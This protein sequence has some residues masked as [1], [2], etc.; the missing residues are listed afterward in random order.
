VDLLLFYPTYPIAVATMTA[1]VM[2]AQRGGTLHA[3]WRRCSA[4]RRHTQLQQHA[5]AQRAAPRRVRSWRRRPRW[6]RAAE[7]A[8]VAA[9]A[10]FVIGRV[11]I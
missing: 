7:A 4:A 11:C 8:A 2:S 1:L 9:C 5:A 6:A 3:A 10:G